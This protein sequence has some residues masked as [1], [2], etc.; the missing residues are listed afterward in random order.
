MEGKQRSQSLKVKVQTKFI[1]QYFP[2][3]I[4]KVNDGKT[5]PG[6]WTT[7]GELSGPI[8]A[9]HQLLS[10]PVLKDFE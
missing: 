8:S 7:S 1:I 3:T 2:Y 6:N 10:L 5:Y 9:E 4:R